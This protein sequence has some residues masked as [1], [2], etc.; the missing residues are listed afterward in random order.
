[1]PQRPTIG[2]SLLRPIKQLQ[3]DDCL[4]LNGPGLQSGILQQPI[5]G[6]RPDYNAGPSEVV[7]AGDHNTYI[8]MGR[9]RPRDKASGKGGTP[10]TGV[11][12]IDLIAGLSG[13]QAREVDANGEP[14]KTNKSPEQD[15]ARIYI[16]QRADADSPEYFSCA[17]G[18]VGNLTNRSAIVIKADSVRMIGREG[19]KLITSP[20]SDPYSGAIGWFIGDDIQGIDLIAGNDDSDLQP[21]VKGDRLVQTLNKQVD[22]IKDLQSAIFI[23][24]NAVMKTAKAAG[25]DVTAIAELTTII[26]DLALNLENLK[27]AEKNYILHKLSYNIFLGENYFLSRHNHTN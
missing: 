8:I 15:A 2:D 21:M 17:P 19:I 14:V 23:L 12:C 3:K 24:M 4:C 9:D 1:M 16:S 18:K 10:N 7:R 13:I 11:G 5:I 22:L 27:K 25:G 6:P 26:P 20:A